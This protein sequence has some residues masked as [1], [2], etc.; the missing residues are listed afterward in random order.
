MRAEACRN[1]K[2][3][4]TYQTEICEPKPAEQLAYYIAHPHTNRHP[5]PHT[6]NRQTNSHSHDPVTEATAAAVAVA[7]S[8]LAIPFSPPP[9]LPPPSSPPTVSSLPLL[10]SV[11]TPVISIHYIA[12]LRCRNIVS[13]GHSYILYVCI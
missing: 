4:I 1:T 8:P 7:A 11:S 3:N 2:H 12:D 10:I 13:P 9:P 6:T 5:P